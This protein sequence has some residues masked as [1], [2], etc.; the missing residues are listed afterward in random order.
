LSGWLFPGQGS[1]RPGMAADLSACRE[2][3]EI[4]REVLQA[5][6]E[7]LCTD[8]SITRWPPELLQP[9]IFTTS[10]GAARALLG[11]G[12]VPEA[13]IGHSLGEYAALV[14]AGAVDFP[15]GLRLVNL[16]GR[17]MAASGRRHPGGM[18]AVIGL[19][20]PTIEDVCEDVGDLWVANVNSPA[21]IVVSGKE[22]S[23]ARA[24]KL[25]LE[26]GAARVVRL[27]VPVAAHSPFME[28]AASQLQ[29]EIERVQLQVPGTSFYSTVDARRHEDPEEIRALLIGSIT[30]RVRFSE[31]ITAMRDA[32][33]EEFI[34]LGP[35]RALRGL[36]RQNLTGVD[37]ASVG[38][39]RDAEEYV[40]SRVGATP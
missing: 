37:V 27:Q 4:G 2:L 20:E 13:V 7:P 29:S 33:V 26:A 12:A 18:A 1:Q 38:S 24:A 22:G 19:D 39:D 25:F 31:A 32:G 8:D 17:A 40:E 28:P 15:D 34:E 23:L 11:R 14:I 35:G 10:I 36:V 9:A 30:Q 3:F 6:L 16:R 5:D 21:Q